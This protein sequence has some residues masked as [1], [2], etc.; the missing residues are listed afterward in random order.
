MVVL[1]I[2][3]IVVREM[4]DIHIEVAIGVHIDV[5]DEHVR[6]AIHITALRILLG[7]NSIWDIEVRQLVAPTD[8]FLLEKRRPLFCKT[9]P[10][11]LSAS[12]SHTS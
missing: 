1:N 10:A 3:L 12:T 6:Q 9:Y 2:P 8:Y 11:K 4:V 5:C 7:L